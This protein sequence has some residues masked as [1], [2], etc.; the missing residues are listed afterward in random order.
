[1]KKIN[2]LID[3]P[4]TKDIN[5]WLGLSF[6]PILY[7]SISSDPRFNIFHMNNYSNE[8]LDCVL[9]FSAGS[10]KIL[11]NKKVNQIKFKSLIM[12]FYPKIKKIIFFFGFFFWFV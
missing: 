9:V 2:L 11:L 1:M 5:Q 3:Y 10:Q 12:L 4:L 7:N 8:N 6:P